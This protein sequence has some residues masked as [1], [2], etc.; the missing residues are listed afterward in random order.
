MIVYMSNNTQKRHTVQLDE[1]TWQWLVDQR[2]LTGKSHK[3][4]VKELIGFFTT[5]VDALTDYENAVE[6]ETK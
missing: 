6:D 4:I 2:A 1:E 5:A 3:K